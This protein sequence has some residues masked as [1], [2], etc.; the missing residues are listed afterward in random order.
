MKKYKVII[1]QVKTVEVNVLAHSPKEAER[2]I[3]DIVRNTDVLSKCEA[4]E[5]FLIKLF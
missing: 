5:A 1:N 3:N 2:R 4:D